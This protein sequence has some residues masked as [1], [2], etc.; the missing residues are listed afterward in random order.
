M[1]WRQATEPKSCTSDVNIWLYRSVYMNSLALQKMDECCNK[2]WED[3]TSNHTAIVWMYREGTHYTGGMVQLPFGI[4][5][6]QCSSFW[7]LWWR[8]NQSIRQIVCN[9][10]LCFQIKCFA[11]SW[12][13]FTSGERLNRRS[14]TFWTF[15]GNSLAQCITVTYYF[16]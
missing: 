8:T 13:H 11:L 12:L 6:C 3:L 4:R 9:S 15:S 14:Q 2:S 7:C 5:K 16:G 10:G 1:Q